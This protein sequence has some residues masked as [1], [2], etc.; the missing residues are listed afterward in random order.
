SLY[1]EIY[2][3]YLLEPERALEEASFA[4]HVLDLGRRKVL[5][6]ASGYGRH[7][8]LLASSNQVVALD[9][10]ADYAREVRAGAKERVA[11]RLFPV[12]GDM[13]NLPLQSKSMDAAIMLFNSFGYFDSDEEIKLGAGGEKSAGGQVW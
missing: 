8:R 2:S 11:Q 10:N 6:V 1:H 7:A 4:S 5:D 9:N 13:R 3:S 12:Q